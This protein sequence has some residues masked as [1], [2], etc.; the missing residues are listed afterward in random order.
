MDSKIE[1]EKI[2]SSINKNNTVNTQSDYVVTDNNDYNENIIKNDRKREKINIFKNIPSKKNHNL[3]HKNKKIFLAYEETFIKQKKEV[4]KMKQRNQSFL[5]KQE[6][7]RSLFKNIQNP[8][9]KRDVKSSSNIF[10][11]LNL[12]HE[13]EF[14]CSNVSKRDNNTKFENSERQNKK[15][16]FILDISQLSE[17]Y[18]N[19]LDNYKYFEASKLENDQYFEEDKILHEVKNLWEPLNTSH[20]FSADG[21]YNYIELDR[22]ALRTV[23]DISYEIN[24]IELK[25]DFNLLGDSELWIFTRSY[26]NKLINESYYFD[27]DSMNVEID[28]YFNKYTSLIKII[29]EKLS[30]KCFITFGTFYEDQN[31][32][33]LIYKTFL[34]RQLVDYSDNL[35]KNRFHYIENDICEFIMTVCDFGEETISAKIFLNNKKKYNNI[36]G[37]F[38]L[39]INKNSKLLLCGKGQSIQMKNI[40]VNLLDKK[41]SILSSRIK[42]ETTHP[43]E[44]DCNCCSVY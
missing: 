25:I 12:N 18:E 15:Q 17:N 32:K 19:Y 10:C 8:Q 22:L 23:K 21:K 26:V 1:L 33:K 31:T 35:K 37:N 40:S 43:H 34:K 39:P 20:L 42:F 28:D 11:A 44:K 14:C 36:H 3:I 38:Y 41:D 9:L 7:K 5:Q 16:D 13:H 2:L 4:E 6:S 27:A 29:K 30:N 24:G